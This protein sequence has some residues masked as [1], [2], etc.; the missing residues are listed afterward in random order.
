MRKIQIV[1]IFAA[2]LFFVTLTVTAQKTKNTMTN[3]DVVEMVKAGL[4]EST[5]VLAI[6]QSEPNFDTSP[7]AL[8]ELSKQGVSQK[9]LDAMLQ[10][11]PTKPESSIRKDPTNAIAFKDIGSLR[12]VLKSILPIKLDNGSI[13]MKL[14]FEFINLDTQKPIVVAMNAFIAESCSIRMGYSLRS[15]LVDE[16]G[17][18][19]ALK[20]SD[21]TGGIGKVGVGWKGNECY[22]PAQIVSVL[23]KRDD[24][25][26]DKEGQWNFIHGEMTDMSPGQS[27]T[28]NMFFTQNNNQQTSPRVFQLATEIVVGVLTSGSKKSYTLYNVT[29]DRVTR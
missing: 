19:W 14:S 24:L 2:C 27:I 21:V 1:L 25:K 12:V 23:S 17:S 8:I 10:T 5:I 15:T 13:G 28:V 6:Q 3:A 9:V 22:D 4:S 7:K 20:N 11:L 29:F 18:V 16:S 26:S